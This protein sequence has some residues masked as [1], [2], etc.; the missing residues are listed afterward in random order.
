[1]N[2]YL[3]TVLLSQL[4]TNTFL[5]QTS[6]TNHFSSSIA[7][8]Q[9]TIEYQLKSERQDSIR[10]TFVKT[11]TFL[12][13]TE[14]NTFPLLN[15]SLLI[16]KQID[17]PVFVSNNLHYPEYAR[18]F[19]C[20][21][22]D[23]VLIKETQNGFQF[24]GKEA[25]KYQMQYLLDSMDKSVSAVNAKKGI[26]TFGID[27]VQEYLQF[28]KHYERRV[29]QA[30]TLVNKYKGK[31]SDYAIRTIM[32]RFVT[33]RLGNLNDK[34]IALTRY[35][36]QY[37]MSMQILCAIY[38]TSYVPLLTKWQPFLSN[39]KSPLLLF[40]INKLRR[41]V[42]FDSKRYPS[43]NKMQLAIY[44]DGISLLKDSAREK[45]IISS[46]PNLMTD[47]APEVEKLLADYYS[48]TGFP[49]WKKW[50]REQE[51][52]YRKRHANHSTPSFQFADSVGQNITRETI[53]QKFTVLYFQSPENLRNNKSD[54]VFRKVQKYFIKDPS[55]LVVDIATQAD[56]DKWLEERQIKSNAFPNVIN[57]YAD[58][59][60]IEE[61]IE[62]RFVIS[63]LPALWVVH[64]NGRTLIKYEQQRKQFL[65]DDG[66][67][68]ISFLREQTERFES[69]KLE[70]KA[71]RKDGPYVFH[72]NNKISAY[73]IIDSTI[74]AADLKKLQA[75]TDI[76]I[77]FTI[78]LQSSIEVQPDEYKRPNKLIALSD[79]EGNFDAFRKLLQQNKIIDKDYNWIFG[80]GHLVFAGDMF[81]R[82]EQVTECLWLA[83]SLEEKAKA[84]GGYVHFVLGNHDIMNLQGK[85][86]YTQ[87]KYHRN[88]RLLNKTLKDVYNEDSELGRWLR[89]KNVIEKIGDLLFLHAGISPEVGRLPLTI[90]DINK[91]VRPYYDKAL[92]SSNKTLLLL[93][94]ASDKGEVYR[95]SPFWSRGYY[96]NRVGENKISEKQLDSTLIKYNV[97]RI[98]TGHTIVADTISVH[99]GGKVIN[100]D[101]HHAD[102]KS[103]A[104]LI[105]GNH[106]Y[107]V[108]DKGQRVL[109]FIDDKRKSLNH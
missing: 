5:S 71:S 43:R 57:G 72:D 49:E 37:K 1:M 108:N 97:R 102:G 73:S 21:P 12:Y 25:F 4:F 83:Y 70:E 69:L 74:K 27:S 76:D 52:I 58:E 85:N 94:N 54:I 41:E 2:T 95:I 36:Q 22:G 79:I 8:Q 65:E 33:E 64:P 86:G 19:L 15:G 45:F 59:E 38:D 56:K 61:T 107:R 51:L 100:T 3:Y 101:T 96:K 32:N 87:Y 9:L 109:L 16:T 89:T 24:L 50:M 40:G 67:K 104:L 35:L 7:N 90:A 98:I 39:A 92:D 18:S 44:D 29:D 55:I 13:Q 106:F 78:K 14:S 48:E 47:F 66:S 80:K 17:Q 23:K 11:G 46:L 93:Y 6:P 63:E 77:P 75:N 42:S 84:A 99:Y 88:A 10:V 105:E 30:S 68:L 82:G 62:K 53:N 28:A 26:A 81:D 34:F 103:E 91:T 20:E 60:D 31:V